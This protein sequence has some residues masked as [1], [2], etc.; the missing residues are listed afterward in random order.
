MSHYFTQPTFWERCITA[1]EVY[2]DYRGFHGKR[3]AFRIAV[4]IAFKGAPF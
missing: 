4:Q 1:W 2:R 3:Y